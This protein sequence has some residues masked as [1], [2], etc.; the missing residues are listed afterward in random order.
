MIE[1][2]LKLNTHLNYKKP[3]II[4]INKTSL[5]FSCTSLVKHIQ[6]HW[7]YSV[8]QSAHI[9]MLE[10]I[11]FSTIALGGIYRVAYIVIIVCVYIYIAVAKHNST[12]CS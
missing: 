10:E 3:C 7:V 5:S 8:N 6:T 11:P 9:L 4:H 2:R 1:N 12:N